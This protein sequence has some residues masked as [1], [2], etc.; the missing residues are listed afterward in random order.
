M[1]RKSRRRGSHREY[2]AYNLKVYT[3]KLINRDF[4]G[5][6]Y[7]FEAEKSCSSALGLKEV[8]EIGG[9]NLWLRSEINCLFMFSIIKNA[10]PKT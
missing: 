9:G 10:L 7:S 4:L 5:G 2:P 1:S 8:K 6:L 3:D